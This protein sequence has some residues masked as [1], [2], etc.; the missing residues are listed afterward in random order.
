MHFSRISMNKNILYI[1]VLLIVP[2]ATH[3]QRN[4]LERKASVHFSGEMLDPFY[5]FYETL[6]FTSRLNAGLEYKLSDRSGFGIQFMHNKFKSYP[7]SV[8]DKDD[9]YTF[10]YFNDIWQGIRTESFET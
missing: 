4:I 5:D 10:S 9:V 2:Q 3:A 7:W 8:W 6:K 1:I